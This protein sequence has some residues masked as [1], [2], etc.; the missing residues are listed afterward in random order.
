MPQ[1]GS[2]CAAQ[3]A[4]GTCRGK[5][6]AGPVS[7]LLGSAGPLRLARD[8]TGRRDPGSDLVTDTWGRKA[9]R[10]VTDG[11][12]QVGPKRTRGP[13]GAEELS[14]KEVGQVEGELQRPGL[15]GAVPQQVAR[16]RVEPGACSRPR[17]WEVR[18]QCPE[19]H[20]QKSTF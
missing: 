1:V 12:R 16:P 17:R 13:S 11:R 3:D 18:G 10:E 5:C 14:H 20:G 9:W 19:P 2:P 7:M 15:L 6:G 8:Y 4:R